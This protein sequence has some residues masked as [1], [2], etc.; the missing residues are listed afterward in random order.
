[1]LFPPQA[2]GDSA[3]SSSSALVGMPEVEIP[4]HP[5]YDGSVQSSSAPSLE[6]IEDP[7][8]EDEEEEEEGEE[9]AEEGTEGSLQSSPDKGKQKWRR[10]RRT[11]TPK[12]KNSVRRKVVV[13]SAVEPPS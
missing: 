11:F 9:E 1:M 7:D 6:S 8:A 12:K 4:T 3:S 2:R 10:K 5:H 13:E